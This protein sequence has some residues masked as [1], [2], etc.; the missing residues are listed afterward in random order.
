MS[1]LTGWGSILGGA[2]QFLGGVSSLFGGGKGGF[3]WN[4]FNAQANFNQ[5]QFNAT[6]ADNWARQIAQ[7]DFQREMAQQ[8]IRYRVE[9]AQRSG[10]SP[11]V[12]LG[13]PTFSPSFSVGGVQPT[14]APTPAY[15]QGGPDFGRALEKMGAG[16]GNIL[17]AQQ[18][19]EQKRKAV[20][21]DILFQQ[22]VKSNDLDIAIKGVQLGVARMRAGQPGAPN[23]NSSS[24]DA[25]FGKYKP[26]PPKVATELPNTLSTTA[27]P[28]TP[29]TTF[30]KTPTGFKP[31]PATGTPAGQ[32]PEIFSPEY[33]RWAGANL[34]TPNAGRAPSL[35][36]ARKSG[37]PLAEGFTWDPVGL[38]WRVQQS[39][40]SPRFNPYG[41]SPPTSY[42]EYYYNR[43]F[44]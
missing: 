34:I 40:K 21:D 25:V 41:K 13:A 20:Q 43:W 2:G 1:G 38:E 39:E 31:T 12:A 6:M 19:D 14:G 9:D 27:G 5:N 37:F 35:D 32:N 30:I 26:D 23:V 8:G 4:A 29:E 36:Y 11:L 22:Q 15:N 24:N 42:I 7:Q 33:A 10:I 18:T 44:K 17:A 28:S 3:D 16:V